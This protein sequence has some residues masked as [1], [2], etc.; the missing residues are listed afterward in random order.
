MVFVDVVVGCDMRCR[1]W[2][3]LVAVLFVSAVGCDVVFW[4][5]LN[6]SVAVFVVAGGSDIY[7]GCCFCSLLYL[8]SLLVVM[9]VGCWF[10]LLV[11][12]VVADAVRSVFVS[13][14]V[15]VVGSVYWL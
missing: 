7:Y 13:S 12:V 11:V 8:S 9:C 15:V 5:W 14:V 2:L 10:C 1:L 6:L 4:L 3:W